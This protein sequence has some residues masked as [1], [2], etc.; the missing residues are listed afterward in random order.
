MN[1]WRYLTDPMLCPMYWPGVWTGLA[2]ALTGAVLSPL[3]VLKRLSF[4]GQGISHAA[5]GG[6]GLVAMATATATTG[7]LV[8]TLVSSP[9]GQFA[10][11]LVFC[12]LAALLI[13]RLTDRA[14]AQADTA[15][16]IVLVGSMTLGALLIHLAPRLGPARVQGWESLLFG[17][18]FSVG[19]ADAA[20]AA[21]AAIAILATLWWF[22][23]PILFWAFDE[24]TAPAFGVRAKAMKTLLILL[25]A[26]AIVAAMKLAGVILA[27]AVLILPGATALRL[28][29]RLTRVLAISV[30]TALAGAVLGLLLSFETNL[31][32]G[33]SIVA[34][35]VTCYVLARLADAALRRRAHPGRTLPADATGEPHPGA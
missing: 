23:R 14:R 33:A 21:I 17:G 29:D 1:A 25:L 35:L 13:A 28:S 27:T 4:V 34:V 32:P 22:R 3:V 5:F 9:Q 19:W 26:I 30:A 6:V 16:G 18:I 12:L 8:A 11:V 15:I 31:P 7:G 10:I 24:A 2:L 20:I